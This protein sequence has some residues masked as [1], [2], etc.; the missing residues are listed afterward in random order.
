MQKCANLA[1][2]KRCCKLSICDVVLLT[3]ILKSVSIEPENEPAKVPMKWGSDWQKRGEGEHAASGGGTE[4]VGELVHGLRVQ[5]VRRPARASSS[6]ARWGRKSS[7]NFLI[8]WNSKCEESQG[9][10]GEDLKS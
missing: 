7:S 1:D 8:T 5:P 10:L 4:G 9:V 3:I 6:S 2:L